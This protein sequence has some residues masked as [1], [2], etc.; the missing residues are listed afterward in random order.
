MRMNARR[1]GLGLVRL[2]FVSFYIS[3]TPLLF[4]SFSYLPGAICSVHMPMGIY[5]CLL[6]ENRK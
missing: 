5:I 6:H 1:L 2:C 3:V 4:V